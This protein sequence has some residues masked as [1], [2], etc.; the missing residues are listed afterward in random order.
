MQEI[1]N[2]YQ[3]AYI[4]TKCLKGLFVHDISNLFQ[5]ISKNFKLLIRSKI[6]RC[7]IG[8]KN[9]SRLIINNEKSIL[10]NTSQISVLNTNIIR[11]KDLINELK[12]KE[13][14]NEIEKIQTK[15]N[16]TNIFR[17]WRSGLNPFFVYR[18][19]ASINS[20]LR[21]FPFFDKQLVARRRFELLS[22][23]PKPVIQGSF[24][25]A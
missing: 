12:N 15:I 19:Y 6:D 25:L 8:V 11:I 17:S 10:D 18:D 1:E 24:N 23:S 16:S 22:T 3:E 9:I 21:L 4:R 14:E 20:V 2:E 5:I 13:I 7:N